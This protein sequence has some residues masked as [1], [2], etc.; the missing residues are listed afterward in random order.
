MVGLLSWPRFLLAGTNL[1]TSP[2][3]HLFA[4]TSHLFDLVGLRLDLEPARGVA[5]LQ[6]GAGVLRPGPPGRR[7]GSAAVLKGGFFRA[8]GRTCPG[9]GTSP[10]R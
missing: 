6:G 8:G 7:G 4:S 9:D 3:S 10:A 5:G 1:N 2:T